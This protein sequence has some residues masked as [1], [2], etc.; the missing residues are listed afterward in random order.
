MT[1]GRGRERVRE[2]NGWCD[3]GVH[4]VRLHVTGPEGMPCDMPLFSKAYHRADRISHG[5]MRSRDGNGPTSLFNQG[6]RAITRVSI[7]I[8]EVP[9]RGSRGVQLELLANMVFTCCSVPTKSTSEPLREYFRDCISYPETRC[10]FQMVEQ[11]K[12]IHARHFGRYA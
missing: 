1:K 4:A 2:Q 12:H 10:T 6:L 11:S 8:F 5:L 7:P 3:I 9:V